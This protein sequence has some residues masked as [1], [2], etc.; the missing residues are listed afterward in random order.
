MTPPRS[1]EVFPAHAGMDR[2]SDPHIRQRFTCSPPTRGWTVPDL[3]K[4]TRPVRTGRSVPR[5]RGD[6]PT[7]FTFSIWRTWCSPPTRGWT[8]PDTRRLGRRCVFPAHA[9]MDRVQRSFTNPCKRVPRPRGD[10]PGQ[11]GGAGTT[12]LCSPPTRG[13][14][15]VIV[16]DDLVYGCSPP[17]RGWTGGSG[18]RG[19]I[20]FVFPAHAGMDRHYTMDRDLTLCVPRPR[21][22]GPLVEATQ[23]ANEACSPPTRGWTVCQSPL[24]QTNSVFPAHAGMDRESPVPCRA[25]QNTW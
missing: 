11:K 2:G 13:W 3:E 15:V 7:P 20:R 6:G 8:E 25:T 23:R 22:D 4:L 17:T 10:G 1:G 14:T 24:N 9:G 16:S 19:R 5:P 18:R 21:G 12:T